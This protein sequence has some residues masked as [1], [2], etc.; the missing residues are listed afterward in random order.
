MSR[1]NVTEA[2]LLIA[3]S[4]GCS[5]EHADARRSAYV[6][7]DGG[8]SRGGDPR[9]EGDPQSSGEQPERDGG[10]A[11]AIGDTGGDTGGCA[12][13]SAT[14]PPHA[15]GAAG[16][17]YDYCMCPM[18]PTTESLVVST[19]TAVSATHPTECAVAGPLSH[20]AA[21]DN[22]SSWD[23]GISATGTIRCW[24]S[25]TATIEA[26]TSFAG[27]TT[28]PFS[29][30]SGTFTSVA[31]GR[32][33]MCGVHTDGTVGCS[34]SHFC[35]ESF[36]LGIRSCCDQAAP[37]SGTFSS[38]CVGNG[39]SNGFSCG[40]RTDGAL[41]CWGQQP[42]ILSGVPSGTA[43]SVACGATFACALTTAGAISCWGTPPA[44]LPTGTFTALAA[45]EN[46][47]CGLKTDGTIA[48]S[49]GITPPTGTFTRLGVGNFG[50]GCALG[51]S[52]AIT[53]FGRALGICDPATGAE[54]PVPVPTG[55]FADLSVEGGHACA[56]RSD[57]TVACW[58]ERP[59][60]GDTCEP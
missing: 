36:C 31:V 7:G 50:F 1:E 40:V 43:S 32:D 59:C 48:C 28:V 29:P 13:N 27:D 41:A 2:L 21:G 35:W 34:A 6:G 45:G 20:V 37:P 54:S 4:I 38:V 9:S 42:A 11:D 47:V 12:P 24:T 5:H 16:V 52:G 60:G 46:D 56:T 58:G 10:V 55:S 8:T 23:C 30:P 39:G 44:G 53:C 25:S 18:R 49:T 19:C 17:P 15:I 33:H 3:L 57:G 14:P 51:A 22:D 26:G